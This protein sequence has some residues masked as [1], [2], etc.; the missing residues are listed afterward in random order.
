MAQ[1]TT[2]AH[3][4]AAVLYLGEE[5]G[6]TIEYNRPCGLSNR[7]VNFTKTMAETAVPDCADP[8]KGDWIEADVVSRRVTINGDGVMTEEALPVWRSAWL[9]D[10]PVPAKLVYY[11][12]TNT[13]T[14]TG[15]IHVIDLGDSVSKG[16]GRTRLNIQAASHGPMVET[17]DPVTP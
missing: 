13:Y 16:D 5:V 2:F 6:E 11:G 14:Y 17:V 8:A 4:K 7:S 12:K 3:D 1:A 10:G 15:L 9:N